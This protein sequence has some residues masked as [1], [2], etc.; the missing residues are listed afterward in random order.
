MRPSSRSHPV[1]VA[2]GSLARFAGHGLLDLLLHR[3]QIEARA[4]LHRRKLDRSLGDLRDFIL[5]E[6]EAP[7]LIDEPVV[8]AD[9]SAILA[10]VHAGPLE[11]VE[12]KIDQD[13]PVH[14]DRGAKPAARLIG[15]PILVV[16]NPYRGEGTLGEVEDFVALR[17]A[18]A[19]DEVHLVVAVEVDLVGAV[20]QLLAFLEVCRNVTLIAGRRDE[21]REPVEAGDDAVLDFAR[22]HSAWPAHD[23]RHAEAAFQRRSLA[24]R[25]RCL[26]AIGPGEIFGA[27]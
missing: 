9:R 24:A 12:T 4:L 22:R 5:H 15:E 6:L 16:T 26:T 13:W 1:A 21:G 10:V 18:L 20:P 7:E 3:L 14:L 2:I 25:E 19:G 27:V 23:H 11:R 8:V 17:R